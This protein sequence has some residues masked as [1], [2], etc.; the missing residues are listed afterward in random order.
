MSKDETFLRRWARRKHESAE[1]TAESRP[2]EAAAPPQLPP[3][4]DLAFESDF[5]DF[6]RPEV[7][8]ET[9]RAALK[10]LFLSPHYRATDG[11]DVYV[12]DY[13]SPDPL[14]AALLAGLVHARELLPDA[15]PGAPAEPGA[16]E[17]VA[18]QSRAS[19]APAEETESVEPQSNAA[20]ENAG[21][22]DEG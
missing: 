20:H 12:G 11:L 14:P 6:M 17:S 7:D 4:E 9:R 3:V 22:P 1:A 2:A 19:P 16:A 8:R 21:L 10:K 15:K 5:K 18:A 13:S